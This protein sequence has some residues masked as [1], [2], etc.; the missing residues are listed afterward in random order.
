[1]EE[2]ESGQAKKWPHEVSR[3]AI[4]VAYE[5]WCLH[6]NERRMAAST[7]YQHMKKMGVKDTRPLKEGIRSRH[8]VLPE[9]DECIAILANQLGVKKEDLI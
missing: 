1:M 8:W 2:M 9:H 3:S 6:R 7:F 4:Y 5:E